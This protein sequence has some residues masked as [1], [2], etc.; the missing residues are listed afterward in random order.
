MEERAATG[1]LTRNS[2]RKALFEQA[3]VGQRF[4]AAPIERQFA[5]DHLGAI[6]HDLLH[7]RVQR[8]A[9]RE[10]GDTLTERLQAFDFDA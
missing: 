8:E 5:R 4:G 9:F 10:L 7:A 6:D 2:H 3:R 1:V